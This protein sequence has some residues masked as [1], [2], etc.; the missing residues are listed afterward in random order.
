ML[1]SPFHIHATLKLVPV[2]SQK[3]EVIHLVRTFCSS[4]GKTSTVIP[5]FY[6]TILIG[7]NLPFNEKKNGINLCSV[8]FSNF[9]KLY[10]SSYNGSDSACAK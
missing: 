10:G 3:L 8:F 4:T 9:T 2:L 5:I 6:F 1:S 7:T